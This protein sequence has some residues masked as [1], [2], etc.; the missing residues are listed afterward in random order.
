MVDNYVLRFNIS[1]HDAFRM[2]VVE[3]LKHLVDVVLAIFRRKQSQKGLIVGLLHVLKD[4]TVDFA[5]L[6]DVQQSHH[7]VLSR[8]RHQDLYLP[9]NL[10]EL[11]C[12]GDGVL[13]LSIL[14]THFCELSRF[15]PRKTSLYLPLPIFCS[16]T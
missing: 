13:G 9:I 14:T 2:C 8:Q 6:Y 5:F 3:S 16:Q 15:S 10:L 1:V 12:V 11:D 7:V 4:Q